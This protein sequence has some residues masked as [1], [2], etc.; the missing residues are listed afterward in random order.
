MRRSRIDGAAI[1]LVAPVL[2]G[3][4]IF[5]ALPMGILGATTI[6]A[7]D[8]LAP[9]RFVGPDNVIA[10]ATDPSILRSLVATGLL[11][12]L[13]VPAQTACGLVLALL[14]S[15]VGRSASTYRTLLLLPW[16]ASPLATGVVWRWILD[17]A[18]GVVSELA[19]RRVE[20]LHDG[21]GA[22]L[23]V[24][25]VLVWGGAGYASL[26][27]SAG[28]SQIPRSTVEA[29][30]LDG[31]TRWIML[32]HILVPQLRPVLLFVVV[33]STVQ[34][35]TTFDVVAALTGG[36]PN[37]ATDVLA[38][39]M[40]DEGFRIFDLGRA[41]VIGLLMMLAIATVTLTQIRALRTRISESP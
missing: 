19:G 22:P 5:V 24:A 32:T 36:G 37:G 16:V 40:F 38:L 12:L 41:A 11:T 6:V 33:T 23:L 7:W 27:F 30:R 25:F 1:A 8:L 35:L 39:R 10:V 20:W 4:A 21:V 34:V 15:R 18:T 31:A 3:I 28:L 2:T 14:F 13:V 9:P 26:F 29:A 17:P